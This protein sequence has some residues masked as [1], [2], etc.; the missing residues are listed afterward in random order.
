M[1]KLALSAAA[2]LALA[3]LALVPAPLGAEVCNLKIATNA[4]PDYG[5]IG[6]MLHS[7]TD[8]WPERW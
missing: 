7:I 5:D 1:T 8:N 6:S 4:N 2:I 3:A